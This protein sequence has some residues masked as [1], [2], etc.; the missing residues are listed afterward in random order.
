[1]LHLYGAHPVKGYNLQ[2]LRLLQQ[3]VP[4]VARTEAEAIVFLIDRFRGEPAV[5]G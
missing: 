4:I 5:G 2:P 1:M 3:P